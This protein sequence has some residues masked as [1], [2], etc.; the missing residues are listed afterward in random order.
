M[1][2]V[3]PLP[4]SGLWGLRLL[5]A[6]HPGAFPS[7]V[8]LSCPAHSISSCPSQG[9]ATLEVWAGAEG[10]CAGILAFLS[11]WPYS[12]M[13]AFS[14]SGCARVWFCSSDCDLSGLPYVWEGL[15][16]WVMGG[17]LPCPCLSL[18]EP[19]LYLPQGIF[20]GLGAQRS[21]FTIFLLRYLS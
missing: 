2:T 20:S 1:Q 11:P 19:A 16:R 14:D 12:L 13:S 4:A 10:T 5:L 8:T 7:L 3:E 18:P 6:A 15:W 9:R 21:A 17:W